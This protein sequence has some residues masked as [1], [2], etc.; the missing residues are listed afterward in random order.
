MD[1]GLRSP[2]LHRH[3][4]ERFLTA[5]GGPS[6]RNS[7]GCGGPFNPRPSR[8]HLAAGGNFRDGRP[9]R[10]DKHF[11]GKR[12]RRHSHLALAP[13]HFR[14]NKLQTNRQGAAPSRRIRLAPI[15]CRSQAPPPTLS[16]PSAAPNPV[17]PKRRLGMRPA[18]R[19]FAPPPLVVP[20]AAWECVPRSAASPLPPLSFPSA[21][22]ECVLRSAA[23]PLPP[24]VPKLFACETISRIIRRFPIDRST[25]AR[26]RTTAPAGC[27][28]RP[29]R[30]RSFAEFWSIVPPGVVRR[31]RCG[32]DCL[33]AGAGA[34]LRILPLGAGRGTVSHHIGLFAAGTDGRR[35]AS[36]RGG[37]V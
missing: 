2:I 25:P 30:M 19:R 5:G 1:G 27:A 15:T 12:N 22:W 32:G 8:L 16:F 26:A 3:P 7:G 24:V 35:L 36:E 6:S 9:R 31:W 34:A 28:G 13:P 18:K 37:V 17:V 21:A 29:C 20:S 10:M 11:R 23:S 33:G 14:T 4:H